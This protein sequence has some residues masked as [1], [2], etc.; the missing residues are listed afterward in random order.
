MSLYQDLRP[1]DFNSMI[2][3]KSTIKSLKKIISQPPIERP[4][5][6]LFTGERGT[7][8][9]TSARILSKEFGAG[10]IDVEELNGSDNRGIDDMR[11]VIQIANIAPMGGKCR[12][13]ILDEIHKL[14]GDA[15]NCLLKVLEDVPKSTYFILCSTDPDKIIKTIRSRCITYRFELLNEKEMEL[16]L[17]IILK[18]IVKDI[19]DSVFFGI[20]NCADG[21]P[22]Q[23]LVL[24]E[25]VLSLEDENEQLNLL[26]KSQI[27]HSIVEIGRLILR[28]SSWKNIVEIYKGISDNEP[29]I[30]RRCLLGYFKSVLL[31]SNDKSFKVCDIIRILEKNTFDGGEAQLLRMLFD[32][33][34]KEK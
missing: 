1:K 31:N 13:F 3:N 2:G 23:A 15:M 12:V 14:T 21:S 33:S 16:L 11:R 22:R 20:V 26:K 4:H 10:D 30:I 28:E 6:F 8:K 7:G 17:D 32:C 29:E 9:T 27:E 24:L 19:P 25:Q 5:T 34:L 18:K